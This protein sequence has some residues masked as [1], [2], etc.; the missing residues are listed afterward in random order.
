MRTQFSFSANP[1]EH[2]VDTDLQLVDMDLHVPSIDS[3]P[4]GLGLRLACLAEYLTGLD[5]PEA[6]PLHRC[7]QCTPYRFVPL[8]TPNPRGELRS[9]QPG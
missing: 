2:L 9:I 1:T 4:A 7:A 6:Q 3:H 8:P 5:N